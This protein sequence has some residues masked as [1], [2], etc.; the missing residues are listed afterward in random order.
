MSMKIGIIAPLSRGY[1]Y[2]GIPIHNGAVL[3]LQEAIDAGD[4]ITFVSKDDAGRPDRT[5]DCIEELD[6]AGVVAILGPVESHRLSE[7]KA[8]RRQELERLVEEWA[9]LWEQEEPAVSR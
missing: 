6:E 1:N 2:F 4:D 7:E 5:R 9:K 8:Q 3:A